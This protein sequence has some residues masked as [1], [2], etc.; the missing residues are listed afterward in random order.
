MGW[1]GML[2]YA[3]TA[4]VTLAVWVVV[5]RWWMARWLAATPGGFQCGVR[6]VAGDLP[7]FRP[8][9][10]WL[11]GGAVLD[12]SNTLTWK[13]RRSVHISSPAVGSRRPRRHE[14]FLFG[15]TIYLFRLDHGVELELAV[16]PAARRV[17][18]GLVDSV[19]T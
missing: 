8:S 4:S 10:G 6:I 17:L 12:A 3:V 15:S 14:I 19:P 13:G 16:R 5:R 11:V 18:G 1:S 7:E 2:V 9:K